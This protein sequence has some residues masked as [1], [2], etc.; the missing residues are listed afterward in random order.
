V[1]SLERVGLQL[2]AISTA[3]VTLELVDGCGLSPSD[4]VQRDRL[5]GAAAEAFDLKVS[6][7]SIESITQR[8]GRLG[9]ALEGQHTFV[10]SFAGEFVGLLAD[11][12]CVLR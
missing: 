6:V 7:P 1:A 3:H 8:G 4:D 12:R 9:R 2:R 11:L 5:V 10:P